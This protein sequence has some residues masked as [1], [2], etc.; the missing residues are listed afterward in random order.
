MKDKLVKIAIIVIIAFVT[1]SI[2]GKIIEKAEAQVFDNLLPSYDS[3]LEDEQKDEGFI[4]EIK[5]FF[6]KEDKQQPIW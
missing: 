4:E 2:G 6:N 1:I 5:D 3:L